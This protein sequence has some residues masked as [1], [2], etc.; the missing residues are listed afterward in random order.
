MY[1]DNGFSA[2]LTPLNFSKDRTNKMFT[3]D[4]SVFRIFQKV[5]GSDIVILRHII[6]III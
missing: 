4:L 5:I 2:L 3:D 6:I 1:V